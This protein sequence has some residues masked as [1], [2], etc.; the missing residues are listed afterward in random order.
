MKGRGVHHEKVNNMQDQMNDFSKKQ[1]KME[2][3]EMKITVTEI[4]NA[5]NRLIT[6]LDIT[7]G[8]SQ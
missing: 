1:K 3:L 5:F 4:K 7:E 8:K 2:M 6:K